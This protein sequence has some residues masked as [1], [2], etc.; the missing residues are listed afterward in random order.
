MACEVFFIEKHDFLKKIQKE[1]DA[2]KEMR[3]FCEQRERQREKVFEGCEKFQNTSNDEFYLNVQQKN[4]RKSPEAKVRRKSF[5]LKIRA[6]SFDD[7][8]LQKK[9]DEKKVKEKNFVVKNPFDLR[10]KFAGSA[11]IQRISN[12]RDSFLISEMDFKEQISFIVDTKEKILCKIK[13]QTDESFYWDKT[14]KFEENF[15]SFTDKKQMFH[16]KCEENLKNPRNSKNLSKSFCKEI[17]K[18]N[19]KLL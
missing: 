18:K 12:K 5:E 8:I 13:K 4:P 3:G 6:K 9:I 11:K 15:I 2:F 7:K 1:S 19:A 16:E 10:R 14:K 17:S